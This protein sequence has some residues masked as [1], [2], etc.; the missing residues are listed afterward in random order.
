MRLDFKKKKVNLAHFYLT[1]QQIML[2]L[3][4]GTHKLLREQ[5][6]DCYIAAKGNRLFLLRL[7][8]VLTHLANVIYTRALYRAFYWLPEAPLS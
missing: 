4:M 7:A 3:G 2:L 1:C 8:S 5:V 6:G